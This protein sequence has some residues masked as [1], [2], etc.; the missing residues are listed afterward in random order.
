MVTLFTDRRMLDHSPPPRHPERPERLQAILRHLD[1]TGLSRR[2]PA[3]V[4]RE[5]TPSR[6]ARVHFAGL[7]RP[8]RRVRDGTAA[9]RSRPIPGSIPARTWPRGSR[10]A[11]RSKPS[12]ACSAGPDRRAMASSGRPDITLARPERWA[13]ASTATSRSPPPMPAIAIGLDRVLI[14]DFDVHHG[15]GTQEIFYD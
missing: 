15:N 7:S 4:V 5:A 12:R 9:A 11:R 14:V 8:G 1:R 6:A 10:P 2:S 13:S 3:G